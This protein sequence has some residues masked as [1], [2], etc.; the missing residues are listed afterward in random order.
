MLTPEREQ[1]IRKQQEGP[2]GCFEVEELLAEIDRLRIWASDSHVTDLEKECD[3]LRRVNAEI[4]SAGK[5]GDVCP[6]CGSEFENGTFRECGGTI[7]KERNDYKGLLE[8][9]NS[10]I[11]PGSIDT[12]DS[13]VQMKKERDFGKQQIKKYEVKI[14]KLKTE[15][16]EYERH[17]SEHGLDCPYYEKSKNL[18]NPDEIIKEVNEAIARA[19]QEGPFWDSS[20]DYYRG[21]WDAL[22]YV[23]ELLCGDEDE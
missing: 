11:F 1:E 13:L 22:M 6:A 16:A 17:C 19:E 18:P 2:D 3:R 21:Q 20:K 12:A 15:L 4:A 14:D 9:L 10:R 7:L 8:E 5:D 23:K